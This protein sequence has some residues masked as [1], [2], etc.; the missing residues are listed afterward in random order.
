MIKRFGNL[1]NKFGVSTV[2]ATL[3][4]VLLA[5]VLVGILWG[6]VN[7][8]IRSNLD[9]S[10]SCLDVFGKLNLNYQYTCYNI[11]SNEF[12]FSISQADVYLEEALIL[13]SVQ[14]QTKT[15]GI[16]DINRS[17]SNIKPFN[18]NYGADISLPGRNAGK[19]YVYNLS[20]DGFSTR[21]DKIEIAPIA[22]D[23]QC[24]PTDN[25]LEISNCF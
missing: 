12:Q 9:K 4:L 14:G 16:S 1:K 20:A 11:T 2:I 15:I 3:I 5:L 18:G 24:D 7:P 17:I 25:L 19:T 21:P 6:V 8:L 22:N 13:V 10:S 23:N